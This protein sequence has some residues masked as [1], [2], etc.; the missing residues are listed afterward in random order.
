[1][2]CRYCRQ[3]Y[4]LDMENYI[5]EFC[6]TPSLKIYRTVRRR[7]SILLELQ[8]DIDFNLGIYKIFKDITGITESQIH[9]IESI[10]PMLAVPHLFFSA[11]DLLARIK[12]KSSIV[13][14]GKNKEWFVESAT[15]FF[16]ISEADANELWKFRNGIIHHYSLGDFI[17][18]RSGSQ[19]VFKNQ[20]GHKVV[21]VRSMRI[22]LQTAVKNFAEFLQQED[23]KDKAATEEYL[24]QYGYSYNLISDDELKDI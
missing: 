19:S 9:E 2:H 11:I 5:D 10:S 13:P 18:S 20:N 14:F 1:M 8:S 6:F 16:G 24:E 22:A 12:H 4:N 7:K 15:L 17:I 23:T 21:F 3:L